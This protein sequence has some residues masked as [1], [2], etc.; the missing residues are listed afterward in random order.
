MAAA[1]FRAACQKHQCK[2]PNAVVLRQLEGQD[3]ASLSGVDLSSTYVG[4]R[5]LMALLDVIE[6]AP[7]FA[8]LDLSKQKIYNTDL[9]P[10]TVKGNT[11]LDRVIDAARVH[12]GLRSLD[13]SGNPLSNFAA[14][15]LHA[16]AADNTRICR[17]G[18][19]DTR[20]DADL[21]ALIAK[22]TAE[23]AGT[24]GGGDGEEAFGAA[25]RA[26]VVAPPDDEDG[27]CSGAQM[28]PQAPPAGGGLAPGR[29]G[30]RRRT[31]MTQS[32]DQEAAKKF[33]AP[34]FPKDEAQ[35][36]LITGLLRSN[37]LF[38]HLESGNLATC[39]DA[40]QR[41]IFSQGDEPLREGEEGN[42]LFV[43]ESGQCDILKQGEKVAEKL[44]GS[45]F[46]ELELMYDTPCVATVRVASPEL[47]TWAL[48]RETYKHLVVGASIRK[49]QQYEVLL[50]S[51]PFLQGLAEYEKAQLA[52]AL[53]S[54]EWAPGA[55]IIEHGAEGEW[56]FL[57]VE[58]T[59]E[60]IGRDADGTEK[61]VCEMTAGEH[62]GE[63]EFFN[64][65]PCV[66]DVKAVTEVTTA[67]INRKHFEMCLGPVMHILKR[68]QAAPKYEY[69]REIIERREREGGS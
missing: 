46:G 52:D 22:K 13:F 37:L 36:R 3:L 17:I 18:L 26:V 9:S 2:K 35:K 34:K 50:E 38:S 16:L 28:V 54:D 5:G 4:N 7:S 29:G 64:N 44:G 47:V 31:V 11:L 24:A 23:N 58:G 57:V 33:K 61:K 30:T 65:H 32:Y 45:A 43:I 27:F 56:M 21:R 8:S 67:K 55:K 68:N 40:M 20:I 60:I 62:F 19:E 39:V 41:K 25:P 6:Q 53:S 63:L 1:A 14:R 69:Y 12:P 59:V 42:T 49:R 66:A 51:V 15:K 48:D 10:D